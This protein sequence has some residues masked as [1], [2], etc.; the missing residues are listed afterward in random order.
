MLGQRRRR[1]T[2]IEPA[3]AQCVVF[4]VQARGVESNVG[5]V[6]CQRRRSTLGRLI[7]LV[8]SVQNTQDKDETITQCCF[9]AGSTA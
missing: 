1:C 5:L 8:G 9:N 4:A 2:N 3:L 7:V 6:L